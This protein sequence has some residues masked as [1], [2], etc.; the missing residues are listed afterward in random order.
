MRWCLRYG[1]GLACPWDAAKNASML[2]HIIIFKI[3]ISVIG[4]KTR[5]TS[6]IRWDAEELGHFRSYSETTKNN[7]SKECSEEVEVLH[8]CSEPVPSSMV[9]VSPVC[10]RVYPLNFPWEILIIVPLTAVLDAAWTTAS[11][12][13]MCPQ[14]SKHSRCYGHCTSLTVAIGHNNRCVIN[15]IH[16]S[17]LSIDRRTL[18]VA[19]NIEKWR[20]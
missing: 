1:N 6:R 12:C 10:N 20:L 13:W 14:W 4:R 9:V 2:N 5:Q 8:F 18:V 16:K 11:H 17:K 15:A 7:W 19:N 3:P